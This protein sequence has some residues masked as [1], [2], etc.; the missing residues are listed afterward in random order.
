MMMFLF[1]IVPFS[2]LSAKWLRYMLSWMPTVYIIAA[3]GAAKVFAWA[4]APVRPARH[5]KWAPALA[6]VLALVFLAQPALASSRSNPY[7]TL[8]LNPLGLGRTGYYFPHDEM[9]DMGLREAI[10]QICDQAPQGASVGGE[11][12]PVF[13]YYFHKFGRDDLQ[14]FD[15]SDQ[16]KRLEA[17]PTAYLVIQDGRKYFENI[18]FIQKV[19]SYQVPILTVEIAGSPA[20]RVYLDE[21]FAELRVGR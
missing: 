9:N 1:W 19:E 5:R 11:T 20:V 8:Y 16:A 12:A 17:P 6:G 21:Q 15:L 3:L 10:R 18:A 7:Y 14:Y 4:A 2:L 13:A